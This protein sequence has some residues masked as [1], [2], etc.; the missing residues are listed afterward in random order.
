MIKLS[1]SAKLSGLVLLSTVIIAICAPLICNYLP[2][3]SS[4]PSL[5]QPGQR[6]FL[7]TD[8]LG[9]DL[10]AQICFGARVSLIVGLGTA[11]LSGLFGGLIGMISGYMGG[12]ID[13]FIMRLIDIMIVLPDLPVMIVLAAFLGPS[14]MNIIIVLTVFSWMIVA[15]IVRSQ[16]LM[17]KTHTYIKTAEMYG[18]GS[19]YIIYKHLLPEIFPLIGVSM[20]RLT[21]RAIVSEAG[22]SFLGLGDPTSKSWG[23]IIHH[24]INFNGIY[25]TNYWKFWLVYP[26]LALTLLVISIAFISRELERIFES[27][28][29]QNK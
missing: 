28:F 15:R 23:M 17:L 8:E 22:L 10:W 14:L 26:W 29:I 20:I 4:G 2:N 12:Y 21:G 27:R 25:Y 6:H 9:Y 5:C 13:K 18:A 1:L 16:V 3:E 11:C 19:W 24:A 7:G